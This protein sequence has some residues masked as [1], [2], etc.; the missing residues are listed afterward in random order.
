[1]LGVWGAR[2]TYVPLDPEY[3]SARLRAMCERVGI[4]V[5]IGVPRRFAPPRRIVHR[6]RSFRDR[7]SCASGRDRRQPPGRART[8]GRRVHPLHLGVVGSPEGGGSGPRE[9]DQRVG[10]GTRNLF[11]RRVGRHHHLHLVQLR[12]V[13][14][15][16]ARSADRRRDGAGHPERTGDRRPRARGDP[17]RQ[18]PVGPLRTVAR[19]PSALD[20]EDDHLGRRDPFRVARE[21]PAPR[22]LRLATGQHLRTDRGDGARHRARGRSA[23]RRAGTDRPPVARGRCGAPRRRVRGGSVRNHRR[24]LH[25]R[26]TG[27]ARVRR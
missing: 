6:G 27:R 8:G 21:R 14:S 23:G 16:G 25:L 22:H 26:P 12:S 10:V 11:S 4:S 9:P 1:M 2:A 5:V 18:H 20:A 7:G 15:G 3:P 13:R 17:A 19:R 24:D